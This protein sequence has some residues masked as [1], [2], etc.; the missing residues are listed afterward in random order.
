M[1]NTLDK[2]AGI[3]DTSSVFQAEVYA[4]L[5]CELENPKRAPRGRTIQICSDSR[6][7]LLVIKS[8]KVKSRLVLECKKTQ[9]DLAS[10]NKVIPGPQDTQ[11]S[12]GNQ[13]ADRLA[14]E[15]S[16]M[17]P[18]GPEPILGV[19]YTMGDKDFTWIQ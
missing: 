5:A 13:E 16:V 8:S 9:N 11:V 4:I 1:E 17:Y 7:A 2:K 18:I 6:T 19:P 14:R 3:A 12:R 15:G 10:S